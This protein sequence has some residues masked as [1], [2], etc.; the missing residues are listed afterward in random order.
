MVASH[1]A[2]CGQSLPR[3]AVWVYGRRL[4]RPTPD[5]FERFLR[6]SVGLSVDQEVRTQAAEPVI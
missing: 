6:E 5:G 1:C 4:Y 3:P 2:H